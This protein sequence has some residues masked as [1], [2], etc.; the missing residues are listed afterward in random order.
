MN[1]NLANQTIPLVDIPT[2]CFVAGFFPYMWIR[3]TLHYRYNIG[4]VWT[5]CLLYFF[6]WS[7]VIRNP[8][9]TLLHTQHGTSTYLNQ[10]QRSGTPSGKYVGWGSNINLSEFRRGATSGLQRTCLNQSMWG[11]GHGHGTY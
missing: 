11:A 5:I 2:G 1:R 4:L 9:R 3:S 6:S 7:N 8:T 10:G